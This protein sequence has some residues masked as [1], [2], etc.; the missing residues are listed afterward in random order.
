MLKVL[1]RYVVETEK[2]SVV[3]EILTIG[4]HI[5]DEKILPSEEVEKF[6]SSN[7]LPGKRS[8]S[9]I[10]EDL[11]EVFANKYWEKE[12]F[13]RIGKNK[14]RMVEERKHLVGTLDYEELPSWLEGVTNISYASHDVITV[15]I[16]YPA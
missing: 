3:E 12:L 8:P 7:P 15:T 9:E 10:K 16:G 11:Q 14:Q 6:D 13:D 5:Y 1:V 2:P 4:F